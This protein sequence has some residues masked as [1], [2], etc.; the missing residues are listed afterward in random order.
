ML[1]WR[2]AERDWPEI[3]GCLVAPARHGPMARRCT[4][5]AAALPSPHLVSARMRRGRDTAL[6]E[7]CRSG[8][9]VARPVAVAGLTHAQHVA[10]HVCARSL[11]TLNTPFAAQQR[12]AARDMAAADHAALATAAGAAMDGLPQFRRALLVQRRHRGSSHDA[13]NIGGCIRVGEIPPRRQPIG[14]NLPESGFKSISYALWISR[15]HRLREALPFPKRFQPLQRPG[16]A[17]QV[18]NLTNAWE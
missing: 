8:S 13:A 14:G 12:R 16:R 4:S 6:R 2:L 15:P 3:A 5:P 17:R 11:E 7:I 1:P 18:F 10:E 9:H